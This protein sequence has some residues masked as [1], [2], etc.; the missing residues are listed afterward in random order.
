MRPRAERIR[1]RQGPVLLFYGVRPFFPAAALWS[2]LAMVLW[3]GIRSGAVTQPS[4]LDPGSWQAQ[5]LHLLSGL[6]RIGACGGFVA[7][8]GPLLLRARQDV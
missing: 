2:A 8:C 5:N 3:T 1:E 7:L 4:A 6:C